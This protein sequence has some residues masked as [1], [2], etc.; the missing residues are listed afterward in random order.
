MAASQITSGKCFGLPNP[1]DVRINDNQIVRHRERRMP[2]PKVNSGGDD[3]RSSDTRLMMPPPNRKLGGDDERR[4][5]G[6]LN[7]FQDDCQRMMGS[8]PSAMTRA[9]APANRS[10]VKGQL[11]SGSTP[12]ALVS[13]PPDYDNGFALAPD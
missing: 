8:P 12:S 6:R 9:D 2:S 10:K 7:S 4:D 1:D 5:Y 13:P 11:Q 3:E